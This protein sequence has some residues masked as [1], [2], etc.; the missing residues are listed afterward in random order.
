[1]VD[2]FSFSDMYSTSSFLDSVYLSHCCLSLRMFVLS[3]YVAMYPFMFSCLMMFL[4]AV[5]I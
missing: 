1:M 2:C 4:F 5:N 3:F